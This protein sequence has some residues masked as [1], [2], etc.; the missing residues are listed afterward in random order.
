MIKTGKGYITICGECPKT[1]WGCLCIT[2]IRDNAV[3]VT[4]EDCK[5]S[6]TIPTTDQAATIAELEA[7][8]EECKN[9]VV[10]VNTPIEVTGDVNVPKFAAVNKEFC[11][12]GMTCQGTEC[13][14]TGED[15]IQTTTYLIDGV[16]FTSLQLAESSGYQL[17]KN[18]I[19]IY[20]EHEVFAKEDIKRKEPICVI[21]INN[22]KTGLTDW[23]L[24]S[25][26]DNKDYSNSLNIKEYNMGGFKAGQGATVA[27]PLELCQTINITAPVGGGDVTCTQSELQDLVDACL[28]AQGLDA[29]SM[30]FTIQ[31]ICPTSYDK[32]TS[33]VDSKTGVESVTTSPSPLDITYSG[34]ESS[35]NVNGSDVYGLP[36]IDADCNGESDYTMPDAAFEL[37]VPEGGAAG[38]VVCV[39]PSLT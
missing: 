23:Y 11:K 7:Y 8:N 24:K 21:E 19:L 29:A 38:V 33:V 14:E 12:D 34:K 28:T 37:V 26:H 5:I 25:D 10:Q 18:S 32:G 1:I 13:I 3:Y 9:P 22:K 17:A 6:C 20:T 2:P 35:V 15:G 36:I 39:T 16:E 30:N 31:T 27:K 4:S